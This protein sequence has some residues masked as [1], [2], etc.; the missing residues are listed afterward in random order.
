MTP[1]RH[2]TRI[3]TPSK[4]QEYIIS[5]FNQSKRTPTKEKK[6]EQSQVEDDVSMSEDTFVENQTKLSTPFF[7]DQT[8]VAGGEIFAFNTPKKRDGMKRLADNTPKTPLSLLKSMSLNTPCKT[9]SSAKKAASRVQHTFKTPSTMRNAIKKG[10]QKRAT[11][12][13]TESSADEHSDYEASEDSNESSDDESTDASDDEE[14]V[15]KKLTNVRK[16]MPNVTKPVQTVTRT[17]SRIRSKKKTYD[18]EC[19]PDSDNYFITASNKKV[20]T[21]F[22]RSRRN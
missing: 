12:S 6:N 4:K 19:I 5:L 22:T 14:N 11:H 9:P 2:S 21:T 15:P 16:I 18:D 10:I 3:R 7:N 1:T 8:D 17:S 13:E 20:S